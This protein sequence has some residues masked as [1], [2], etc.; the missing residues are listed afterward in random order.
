MHEQ[1]ATGIL[2][3]RS[4]DSGA[5]L[6]GDKDLL[7]HS[8]PPSSAEDRGALEFFSTTGHRL[9]PV[10]DTKWQ[11]VDLVQ[12]PGRPQPELVLRRLRA[13]VHN[14][15]TYLRENQDLVEKAGLKVEDGLALLPNL[16]LVSLDAALQAWSKV[17]G[18]PGKTD[19]A[20]PWHNFWV[21]GIF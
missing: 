1:K 13:T 9:S 20:D 2:A 11:I 10:F 7:L 21:H 8:A 17:F 14:M 5:H 15:R 16:R 19:V 6:Y 18:H 12:N 3:I 4:D